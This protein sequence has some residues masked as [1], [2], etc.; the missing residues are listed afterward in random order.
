MLNV[1]LP[2]IGGV[3]ALYFSGLY[4]SVPATC[5]FFSHRADLVVGPSHFMGSS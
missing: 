2:L 1:P 3:V 4:P 5:G